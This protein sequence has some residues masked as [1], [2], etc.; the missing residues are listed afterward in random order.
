MLDDKLPKRPIGAVQRVRPA[1]DAGVESGK[2]VARI[3][4][5]Q[6][7][8]GGQQKIGGK[9]G[10]LRMAG[11]HQYLVILRDALGQGDVKGRGEEVPLGGPEKR[12]RDQRQIRHASPSGQRW[13]ARRKSSLGQ[14]LVD[15]DSHAGPTT[16]SASHRGARYCSRQ[17]R[18]SG[19]R[20]G[21]PGAVT[22][23]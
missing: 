13:T 1:P 6:A 16:A 8:D 7:V 20:A 18:P 10:R 21:P 9:L 19:Q 22:A 2:W 11:D 17:W 12:S 4:E 15:E 14:S 3:F 23:T 5:Q